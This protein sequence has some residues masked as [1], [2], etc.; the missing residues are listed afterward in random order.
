MMALASANGVEVGAAPYAAHPDL[1]AELNAKR[2]LDFV[3]LA[4]P[5]M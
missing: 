2:A 5:A 4:V 1:L 3:R